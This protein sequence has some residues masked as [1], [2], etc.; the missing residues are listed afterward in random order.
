MARRDLLT[1]DER[2]SLFGVPIDRA[3]LAAHYTLAPDDLAMLATR[4]GDHNRLGAA[5]WLLLLRHPGFGLRHDEPPP[6]ELVAHV[7]EQLG[8]D[9]RALDT[10]AAR[11]KT[12]TE[13]GWE[14]MRCLGLRGFERVDVEPSIAAAATRA[15]ETDKGLPIAR[16]VV[17]HLRAGSVVLPAPAR[18]ERLSIA[19]RAR[20]RRLAADMLVDGLTSEQIEAIDAPPVVDAELGVTPL[21]WLRDAAGAPTAR[22]L[23]A[24]LKRLK[25]VRDIGIDA[26]LADRIHPHRFRQLAREGAVAPSFLL[27]DY[28]LRRR[29]ATIAARLIDLEQSLA[30]AAVAMF[31]KQTASLFARAKVRQRRGY[32]AKAGDVGRLMRAFG[33]TIGAIADAREEGSDVPRRSRSG[34]A[35]PRSSRSVRKSMRSWA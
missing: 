3:S 16:A 12:R 34:S 4:R 26:E 31:G 27:S 13:H 35:S 30:D 29:R 20:A 19:G 17:E 2:G 21:A 9:L 33:A 28:S 15:R 32:A 22:N 8:A 6:H 1:E 11:E 23:S 10:Y 5:L 7:A 25:F 24:L 18:I 14:M